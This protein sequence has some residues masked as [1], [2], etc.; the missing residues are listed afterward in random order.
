M[1]NKQGGYMKLVFKSLVF[2]G[3]FVFGVSI[4]ATGTAVKAEQKTVAV[5]A[6]HILVDTKE[7]AEAIEKRMANGISFEY[8]A[9]KYSKCPSSQ[10]GGDLGFFRRGQMVKE[11][12]DAAFTME[13]G[14][15]SAPIQTQ[16]GWHII[17]VTDK[18]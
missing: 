13:P 1:V 18:K 8:L 15:I 6:S 7:E 3:L 14:D 10:K 17:K 11:F 5:K 4:C 12:E 2:L 16:F 9:Q